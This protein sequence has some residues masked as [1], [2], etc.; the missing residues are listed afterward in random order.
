MDSLVNMALRFPGFRK[1]TDFVA[2]SSELAP[3]CLF[4]A[5]LL[6]SLCLLTSSQAEEN[7]SEPATIGLKARLISEFSTITANTPFTVGFHIEHEPGYHTYWKNPG[8]VGMATSLDWDLPEGFTASEIQWPFPER[9]LMAGH[10]C[11]GYERDVTLLV[12]I[13]PPKVIPQKEVTLKT[14]AQWMCCAK[15]CHPGFEDFSL[16]LSVGEK[17]QPNVESTTLISAARKEIPRPLNLGS[18]QVSIESP[19]DGKNVHLLIS[20]QEDKEAYFFSFDGQ[21]SSEKPQTL[22]KKADG[23]LSLIVPRSPYAPKGKDS[24]PGILQLGKTYH[25]INPSYHSK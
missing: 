3:R 25:W 2:P 13:T 9:S 17:T 15:N 22:K 10:P 11:H 24:L 19:Q 5:S 4:P 21:I 1:P 14:S 18:T 8:I 7:T 12:T 16:T 20:A 23:S 6:G